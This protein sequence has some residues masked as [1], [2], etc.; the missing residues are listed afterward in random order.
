[1]NYKYIRRLFI[2]KRYGEI[3]KLLCENTNKWSVNDMR[4]LAHYCIHHNHFKIFYYMAELYLKKDCIASVST[5]STIDYYHGKFAN[6]IVHRDATRE[7]VKW[8]FIGK[9]RKKYG[10]NVC[11]DDTLDA[12]YNIHRESNSPI[13]RYL[14]SYIFSKKYKLRSPLNQARYG[15]CVM[16]FY[17]IENT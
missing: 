8:L 9:N 10:H 6:I 3:I 2:T 5:L 11:G 17:A 13:L 16:S 1:M 14:V 4:G 7:F 12:Y 15:E